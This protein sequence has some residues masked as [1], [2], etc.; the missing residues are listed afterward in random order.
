[1]TVRP[2]RRRKQLLD[3]P[4]ETRGYRKL[5]ME[6]LDRTLWRI[7]IRRRYGFVLRQ[8]SEWMNEWTNEPRKVIDGVEEGNLLG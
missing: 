4:K 6:A 1:M 2:G 7:R 8:T 3:D 5:K